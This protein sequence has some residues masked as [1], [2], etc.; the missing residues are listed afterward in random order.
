MKI[1]S[2]VLLLKYIIYE[3]FE[4]IKIINEIIYSIPYIKKL[5]TEINLITQ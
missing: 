2:A 5:Y 3:I 1:L 4:V